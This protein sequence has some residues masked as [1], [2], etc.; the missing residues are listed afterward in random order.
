[1]GVRGYF[2]RLYGPDLVKAHKTSPLYYQRIFK[3]CAL[4]S[5]Q[6]LIIDDSPQAITHARRAGAQVLLVDRR[7]QAL[8]S[9][10]R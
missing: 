9:P 3:Q 5:N 1:M 6:A 4:H 8:V 7:A 2:D 10:R